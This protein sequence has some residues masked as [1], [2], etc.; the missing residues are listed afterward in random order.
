MSLKQS[1]ISDKNVSR[2]ETLTAS[3]NPE[4]AHLAGIVLEVVRVKPYRK[5]RL[6][7]LA[8]R[9]RDLLEQLDETGL[10]FAH[11]W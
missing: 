3:P 9:R 1:H 10:I 11:H 2:L 8:V 5:R 7:F 4:T 6:K